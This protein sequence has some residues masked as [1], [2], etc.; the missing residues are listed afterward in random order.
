LGALALLALTLGVAGC[1]ERTT[2][3]D[4]L[5]DPGHY[6]NKDVAIGGRVTNSYG[7]LGHGI[8]EI[9]DGTGRMWV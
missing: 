8:F 5:R 1:P 2:I 6:R 3:R 4:V 7:A 9:D